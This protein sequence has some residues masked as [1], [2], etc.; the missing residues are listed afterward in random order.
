M[1]TYIKRAHSTHTQVQLQAMGGLCDHRVWTGVESEIRRNTGAQKGSS[2]YDD[3]REKRQIL[4]LPHSVSSFLCF[5]LIWASDESVV[6]Q[7]FEY[8][9]FQL[10]ILRIGGSIASG[11]RIRV[12]VKMS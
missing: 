3:Y 10:I 8:I 7:I 5:S 6:R 9:T 11:I 12:S 1:Y 4:V 2:R